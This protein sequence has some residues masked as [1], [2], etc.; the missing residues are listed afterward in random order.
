MLGA[1]RAICP[2]TPRLSSNKRLPKVSAPVT[3]SGVSTHSDS[4]ARKASTA[5]RVSMAH[6]FG[7]EHRNAQRCRQPELPICLP[8]K[9]NRRFSGFQRTQHHRLPRTRH[10]DG[11]SRLPLLL[12]HLLAGK[13]S[14]AGRYR[15]Y[16]QIVIIE[17]GKGWNTLI[18]N[19]GA[20][21]VSKGRDRLAKGAPCLGT[22]R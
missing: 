9:G 18:T 2:P 8:A 12:L 5:G 22:V 20:V 7:C 19:L 10:P 3:S 13:I 16:G 14:F 4:A 11:G 15:S 6:C 1:R 17:H 21:Q